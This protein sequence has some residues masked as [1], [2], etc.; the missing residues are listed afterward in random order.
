MY[1]NGPLSAGEMYV[2]FQRL[3]VQDALYSTS[4]SKRFVV[5]TKKGSVERSSSSSSTKLIV[6]VTVASIVVVILIA[7]IFY[8]RYWVVRSAREQNSDSK[9]KGPA[10][11]SYYQDLAGNE[12]NM[13]QDPYEDLRQ[14]TMDAPFYEHIPLNVRRNQMDTSQFSEF[15]ISQS[16]KNYQEIRKEINSLVRDYDG[17]Y[18]QDETKTVIEIVEIPSS[19]DQVSYSIF[20]G[21]QVNNTSE[22]W[23]KVFLE[24][25]EVVVVIKCL[26]TLWSDK[27]LNCEKGE[28]KKYGNYNVR[29]C[30]TKVL[31]DHAIH[32]VE[33]KYGKHEHK[34]CVY[35][36]TALPLKTYV[37]S[38]EY[39]MSVCRAFKRLTGNAANTQISFIDMSGFGVDV[40]LIV[41]LQVIMLIKEKD[42]F[43]IYNLFTMVVNKAC[44]INV[45]F[46]Q[47][48]LIHK[49]IWEFITYDKKYVSVEDFHNEHKSP[50][51]RK[52]DKGRCF[53]EGE[54]EEQYEIRKSLKITFDVAS[55]QLN[56]SKN[57]FR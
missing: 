42:K 18:L 9:D 48:L 1:R 4:W 23:E 37:N 11:V 44:S 21:V 45:C 2:V 49:M 29:L 52:D 38:T 51:I 12:L 7:V 20:Q 13:P 15:F 14:G 35:E 24:K 50:T 30:E 41:F 25:F 28:S 19:N 6:G 57:L 47:Y 33:I 55:S 26:N 40:I 10:G 34:F 16:N 56:I 3:H 53:V 54:F 22:I 5:P 39:L 43:D 27:V 32:E 36:I 31:T 46:E 17:K 8:K